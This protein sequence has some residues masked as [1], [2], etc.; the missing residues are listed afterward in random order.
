MN[1]NRLSQA[2]ALALTG[3]ALSLAPT[4]NA[5]AAST[6]MYNLYRANFAGYGPGGAPN[7]TP[8][9]FTATSTTPCSPCANLYSNPIGPDNGV[10][11]ETDG[12][13]WDANPNGYTTGGTPVPFGNTQAS[14]DPN[15]PGWVGI[16]GSSTP[17]LTTPF[18][19][20]ARVNL[21]WA[22][23]MQGYGSAEI[24][25]ADSIARGTSSP[26][27]STRPRAHGAAKAE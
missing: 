7:V 1:H 22:V 11:N 5:W 17:T 18:G 13:V 12:W 27:T 15:R 2:I 25:N 4:S 9:V 10:G 3:S 6:T 19:Y 23:D 8:A 24:S 16:G 26:P 21:N 20:N 14:A